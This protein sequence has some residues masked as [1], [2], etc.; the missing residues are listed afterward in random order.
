MSSR[1]IDLTRVQLRVIV[2]RLALTVQRVI[3]GAR[4]G[5][6]HVILRVN[7]LIHQTRLPNWCVDLH[8]WCWQ[9]HAISN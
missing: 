5:V 1:V 2:E 7:Y 6:S 8:L 3:A 4:G 9:K